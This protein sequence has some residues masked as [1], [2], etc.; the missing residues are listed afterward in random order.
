[1]GIAE[2]KQRHK[3]KLRCSILEAAWQLVMQAE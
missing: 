2:R 1:M 3:E